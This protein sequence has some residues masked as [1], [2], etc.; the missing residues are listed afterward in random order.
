MLAGQVVR[1]WDFKTGSFLCE[2]HVHSG[3]VN[4]VAFSDEDWRRVVSV[5]EDGFVTFW[6]VVMPSAGGQ[7]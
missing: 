7:Q 1:V 6:E 4:R 3:A 5:G 2:G